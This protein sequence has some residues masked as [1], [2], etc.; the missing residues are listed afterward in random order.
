MESEYNPELYPFSYK[1]FA[2]GLQDLSDN[3]VDIRALNTKLVEK[4]KEKGYLEEPYGVRN[5]IDHLYGMDVNI[6]DYPFYIF[7]F[8]APQNYIF[9][10]PNP[11]IDHTD[12]PVKSSLDEINAESI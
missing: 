12:E 8:F 3:Q 2:T 10:N 9:L 4:Y 6:H 1:E 7:R 11:E 5:L